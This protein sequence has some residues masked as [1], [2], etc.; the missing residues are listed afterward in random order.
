MVFRTVVEMSDEL[1]DRARGGLTS[2]F[3]RLGELL[4]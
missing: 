2:A 1:R 3:D 4:A